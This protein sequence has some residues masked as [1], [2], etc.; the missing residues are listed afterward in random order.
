MRVGYSL[1]YIYKEHFKKNLDGINAHNF[2]TLMAL[3]PSRL[4]LVP[5][6][7]ASPPMPNGSALKKMKT[8]YVNFDQHPLHGTRLH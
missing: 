4:A 3:M 7:S 2:G 5:F 1:F 6:I 8:K